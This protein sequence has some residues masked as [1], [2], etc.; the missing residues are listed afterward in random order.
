M[1]LN[2]ADVYCLDVDVLHGYDLGYCAGKVTI[3]EE[4]VLL[5]SRREDF[6]TQKPKQIQPSTQETDILVIT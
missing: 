3:K 1:F 5:S 2:L 4:H 6:F